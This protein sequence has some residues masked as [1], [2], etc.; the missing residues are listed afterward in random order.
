MK[1]PS[2]ELVVA[3]CVTAAL[4]GRARAEEPVTLRFATVAPDGSAWARELRAMGRQ[5]ETATQGRV[6]LKWYWAAVAGDEIEE[7]ERIKKGQL[8]GAAF[9]LMC[10]RIAPTVRITRVPGVFQSLDEATAVMNTLRGDIDREAHQEGFAILSASSLGPDTL[11]LRKP[12]RSMA[13]LRKLRVW[14]WDVDESGIALSSAMGINLVPA[15]LWDASKL[16]AEGRTDGFLG[17]PQAALAFQWASQASYFID[18]AYNFLWGCLVLHERALVRLSA[19]D[20]AAV[21]EAGA[22]N[23]ERFLELGRRTDAA[24]LGG[25]FQAAGLKPVPV[26]DAQRAEFFKAAVTARDLV[27]PRYVAP[28]LLTRVLRLLADYRAEHSGGK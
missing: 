27:G 6:R 23:Q 19:A 16:Y 5:V 14:R 8:D 17:V 9:G 3:L 24:L 18:L 20:Q 13:E 21:R 2:L 1:R 26:S 4:S 10:E 15:P 28:A 11:L 25:V 22:Q 7:L 12:V